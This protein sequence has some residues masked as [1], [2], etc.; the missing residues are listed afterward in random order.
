MKSQSIVL[1]MALF[2]FGTLSHGQVMPG[3]GLDYQ[4]MMQAMEKA[5]ADANRPGDPQLTCEQLQEQLVAIAQ[6]PAFLAHMKETGA[7]AEK[8]MAELQRP[9]SAEMAARSAA[10]MMASTVPGAAMGHTA[11]GMA[12][13]QA[14]VAQGAARMQS[15]MADAQ[16]MMTFLPQM[17]RGE[18][19]IGLAT[20]RK[21][22]WAENVGAGGAPNPKG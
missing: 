14:K 5:Q 16:K 15:K 19:L 21:C 18:R 9:R 17:M 20:A 11:A 12:E 22:E 7:A 10:T 1:G 3:S 6:D 8:E 4:A 13:N 2:T